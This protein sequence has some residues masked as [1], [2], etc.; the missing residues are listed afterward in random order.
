MRL[1]RFIPEIKTYLF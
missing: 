1:L